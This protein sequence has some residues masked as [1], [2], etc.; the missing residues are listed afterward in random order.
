MTVAILVPRVTPLNV[1]LPGVPTFQAGLCDRCRHQRVVRNTRGSSFSL[2]E[3]HRT[4]PDLFAKYPRLPVL[5]CDGFV[6]N[7]R[8]ADA[9]GC[10]EPDEEP[11]DPDEPVAAEPRPGVAEDPEEPD[12]EPDPVAEDA[13]A[14]SNGSS[15]RNTLAS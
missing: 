7:G 1:R 4:E 8:K 11:D 2:C 13:A 10:F 15:T 12:D 9:Q 6:P 3:R 5:A 14:A